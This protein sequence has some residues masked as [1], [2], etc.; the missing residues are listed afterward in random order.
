MSEPRHA[1]G[2]SAQPHG[3]EQEV[4][5]RDH[6]GTLRKARMTVGVEVDEDRELVLPVRE[7]V[8]DG[9]RL[10]QKRVP[11]ALGEVAP[12]RYDVLEAEVRA[13]CRL[14]ATYPV[15]Y[16]AGLARLHGYDV[17]AAEPY[18]LLE[19]YRGE[20]LQRAIDHLDA[21]DRV[22]VQ[23]GLLQA[24]VLTARAHVVHGAVDV[25]ALR[26][27]GR[28]VQLVDFHGGALSLQ[29]A[30]FGTDVSA[31]G[32]V[33]RAV[34]LGSQVSDDRR[35]DPQGLTELLTDVFAADPAARPTSAALL[36]R[37]HGRQPTAMAVD[38]DE[39]WTTAHTA[40]DQASR[41]K[42]QRLGLDGPPPPP[43]APR[44]RPDP[45]TLPT[46]TGGRPAMKLG[47]L[48]AAVLVVLLLVLAYAIGVPR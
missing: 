29:P 41:R 23:E 31:A 33:I 4:R 28:A 17:D 30:D 40:F 12:G 16:P 2:F 6:T 5:Y 9:L 20:P 10:W 46:P 21:Q 1:T 35:R 26:W 11:A 42:R 48:V 39:R 45:P 36:A 8:V 34:V 7:V 19:P 3:D 14:A 13:L 27:H 18:V 22:A 43:S 15:Q 37:S 32:R 25:S 24:L 44:G 47:L 38:P